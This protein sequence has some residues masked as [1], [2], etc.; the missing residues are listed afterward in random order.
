MYAGSGCYVLSISGNV[1]I[2]NMSNDVISSLI[3]LPLVSILILSVCYLLY[4]STAIKL[5][6]L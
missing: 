5:V 4:S 1:L 3:G 6:I 2:K